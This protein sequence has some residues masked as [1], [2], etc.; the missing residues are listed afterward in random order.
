[1]VS[2]SV[3]F[4]SAVKSGWAR[5]FEYEGRSSRAEYWWFQLFSNIVAFLVAFFAGFEAG[6]NGIPY[7]YY[8]IYTISISIIL[9]VP[10]LSLTFRRRH[11]L[12]LEGSPFLLGQLGASALLPIAIWSSPSDGYGGSGGSVFFAL[13]LLSSGACF[14]W[15]LTWAFRAGE[16]GE[17]LFGPNPLILNASSTPVVS[18]PLTEPLSPPPSRP[19][20]QTPSLPKS[21]PIAMT[22]QP[23]VTAT[24]VATPSPSKEATAVDPYQ[25]AGEEL[26][27]GRLDPSVW[28]RALVEGGGVEGPTKAAYVKLRVADLERAAAK[29]A[30]LSAGRKA[31]A[32]AAREAAARELAAISAFDSG[33][34]AAAIPWYRDKAEEGD[35]TVQRRLAEMLQSGGTLKQNIEAVGWFTKAAEQ[36][37][38]AAQNSL[39]DAYAKGVGVGVNYGEAYMWFTLASERGV[40]SGGMSRDQVARKMSPAEVTE[41][42]RRAGHWK[43][44]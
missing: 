17:N 4:G 37:D 9:F 24:P 35:A 44:K 30:K 1:V 19:L 21:A 11:D 14:V 7:N 5:A 10:S 27:S 43:P 29:A 13:W 12:G 28:A 39:A 40:Q 33:D 16:T 8:N 26:I 36:G 2:S 18:S 38:A 31:E 15:F 32:K 20:V 6:A 42:V 3:S 34:Y 41:A 23:D 22:T 25:Q